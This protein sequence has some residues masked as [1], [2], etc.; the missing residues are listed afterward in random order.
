MSTVTQTIHT[1]IL[2]KKRTIARDLLELRFDKPDGLSFRAGQFIQCH[3]PDGGSMVLRSYSLSSV[4]SD[5]YIELC[6]K[7][8]PEGKASKLF[9]GMNLGD[10][11]QFQG[12]QGRFIN[13]GGNNPLVFVA[14]GAGM[15]PVM[16]MLRDEV[17][18]KKNNVPVSVLFGVRS[19]EDIFWVERLQRLA[20]KYVNV[21]YVLT[22]SQPTE[23]W[24]GLSGRVT[25]HMEKSIL[26]E[27]EYFL[28]GSVDM[29]KD[30]RLILAAAGVEAK[31]IHF[32]IF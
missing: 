23:T 20:D 12:P 14:T 30:V 4:P 3:V 26:P 6:V 29:V 24:K 1:T 31:K 10:T 21:R 25:A 17:E 16:S 27:A 8:L 2:R 19:E 18:E 7:L 32:E 5:P 13:A 22:L 15:A 9:A 28:C 11:L